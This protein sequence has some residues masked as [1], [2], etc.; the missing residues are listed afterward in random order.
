M[1]QGDSGG[2]LMW[3][4]KKQFY[5]IGIHSYGQVQCGVTPDVY[6]KVSSYIDW[7]LE[8]I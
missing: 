7:I 4:K 1:F 3:L 5:L 2:P 8:N 6:T